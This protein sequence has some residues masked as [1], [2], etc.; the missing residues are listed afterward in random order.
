MIDEHR[1]IERR[2]FTHYMQILDGSTSKLMGHLEDISD[3]GF[4]MDS[5]IALP[6]EKDFH[7]YINLT[8]EVAT[9]SMLA[10]VARSK[11][12]KPDPFDPSSFIVGFQVIGMSPSDHTI[13]HRMF[14]IYGKKK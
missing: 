3:Y 12:C 11:W 8:S 14:E 7:L 9:K 13:F 2:Q 5:K 4:R 10:F 1:K 6:L